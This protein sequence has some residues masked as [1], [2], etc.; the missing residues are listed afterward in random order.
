MF[1]LCVCTHMHIGFSGGQKVVPNTLQLKLQMAVSPLTPTMKL[2]SS[3]RAVNI[4]NCCISPG[5]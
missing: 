1:C 5:S 4:V 2:Q 3:A